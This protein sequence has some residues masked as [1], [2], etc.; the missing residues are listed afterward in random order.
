MVIKKR[1]GW[2]KKKRALKTK[3]KLKIKEK[4]PLLKKNSNLKNT[5]KYRTVK[6][7]NLIIKEKKTLVKKISKN[8]KK[9][10]RK[11]KLT[12]KKL[13]HSLNLINTTKTKVIIKNLIR[14][15][16]INKRNNN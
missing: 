10:L 1:N 11:N 2:E 7:V 5:L 15:I 14:K 8:Q 4:M 13:N 16:S 3:K 12:G 9:I 6:Q